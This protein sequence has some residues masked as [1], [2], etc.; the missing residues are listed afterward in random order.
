MAFSWLKG[1]DKEGNEEY[2][3][4]KEDQERMD[5]AAK[6]A[7]ELPEIKNKLKGL[8][9]VTE[10]IDAFKKKQD[11][12]AAALEARKRKE[13]QQQTNEELETLMLTDPVK[14]LAIAQKPTQDAL[15]TLRADNLR[16]EVFEDTAKFK[17]YHGD[18]KREVDQLI[19]GQSLASKNDPSVIE[20]CYLTVLGRH[21]DE[22]LEGK[23]KDRF[24]GSDGGARGTS[25]GAAGSTGTG[26]TKAPVITDDIR[27]LA[28]M[29]NTTP[30]EYAKQ[31]DAEGVG[32][33]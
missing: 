25:S 14:A 31:L 5:K 9:K 3:L 13:G 29:F 11:D 17:Y 32:Y 18:I 30:E 19:A 8:D 20:N 24:A 15:L 27:K 16:R 33:V 28:K 4:S 7:E 23:I 12:D 21:N 1:K 22:I 2:Q 26:E 10:F 6:A